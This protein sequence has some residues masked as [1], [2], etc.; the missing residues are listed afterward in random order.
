MNRDDDGKLIGD[1]KFDEVSEI[2]SLITPVPGGVEPM[3]ITMLMEQTVRAASRK[4]NENKWII[5]KR[6]TKFIV[7]SKDLFLS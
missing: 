1:V 5:N 2:A 6:V 7:I 3:T 4:I